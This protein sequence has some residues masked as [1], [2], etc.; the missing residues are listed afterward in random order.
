MISGLILGLRPAKLAAWQAVNF[1]S[2]EFHNVL[3][4]LEIM[5]LSNKVVKALVIP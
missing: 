3:L 2:D 5:V 4:A 1:F